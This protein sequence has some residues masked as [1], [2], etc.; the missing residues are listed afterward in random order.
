MINDNKNMPLMAPER[1]TE[2]AQ[3]AAQQSAKLI[4]RY[5]C[6]LI[7]TEHLL[8]AMLEQPQ[9]TVSSILKYLE[10]DQKALKERLD[11]L[12]RT[13]PKANTIG[14]GTGQIYITPRIKRLIECANEEAERLG[15]AHIST[16]LLLLAIF[17]E[18]DTLSARLLNG[19]GLTREGISKII[20]EIRGTQRITS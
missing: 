17:D 15:D 8:L 6:N 10:V 18:R 12:L 13:Y 1:F 14:G 5:G 7:D 9:G 3:E 2:Q 19:V 20:S 16:E 4:Q 11:Y